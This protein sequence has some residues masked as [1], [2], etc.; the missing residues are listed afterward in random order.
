MQ[1][2]SIFVIARREYLT[3]VKSKSFWL[4][5]LALPLFILAIGL[6]P[7]LLLTQTT[8]RQRLAIVDRT[9]VVGPALQDALAS[10]DTELGPALFTVELVPP[11]EDGDAQRAALDR[12]ILADEL[13]AWI[14]IDEAGLAADRVEYHAESV[15]NFITQEI[16]SRALSRVV[17]TDRLRGAGYDAEQIEQL[18]RPL[19]LATVRVSEEGS[20]EEGAEAAI[21]L[22]Y[23]LFFLL[24]MVLVIYGQQVMNGVLEEKSSRVVELIVSTVR[25]FELMMGKLVGICSVGLTQLAIWMGTLFVLTLPPVLARISWIPEGIDI[26][27]LPA[28]LV[29]HFFLFFVLGFFVYST[30]YAAIGASF[31]SVQEAQQFASVVVVLLVAPVFGFWMVLNDPDSTLAVAT[32]LVPLFTPLLMMLR[33]AVKMPPAWQIAL[34]YFL[35]AGFTLLMVW[36]AARIYR[37]GIL[38]YGKKPSPAELWRWLRVS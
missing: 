10:P 3:R 7:S 16:L 32:S 36:V 22:A 15:S 6:I 30:L 12:R 19:G 23:I 33:M 18:T 24:Y 37:V 17:Q 25:P 35:T 13:D 4:A 29:V 11:G 21:I 5:T 20:E 1:L 9:G 8:A 34:G 2:D 38:M 14:W 27:T 31:N 28:G 26:P